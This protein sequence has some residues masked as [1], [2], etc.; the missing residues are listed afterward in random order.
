MRHRCGVLKLMICS[1][2]SPSPAS[3][4]LWWEGCR[5]YNGLASQ[6]SRGHTLGGP[7][8]E[9]IFYSLFVIPVKVVKLEKFLGRVVYV[10]FR[11]MVVISH[12]MLAGILLLQTRPLS[13]GSKLMGATIQKTAFSFSFYAP[14]KEIGKQWI[15]KE[16]RL[17]LYTVR[18]R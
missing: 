13:M 6:L 7:T 1:L 5:Q 15:W 3:R 9:R 16:E 10:A 14:S 18:Y 8:Y 12:G 2:A 4:W 11:M 17:K